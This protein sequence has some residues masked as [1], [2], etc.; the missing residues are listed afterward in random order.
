MSAACLGPG[1]M[2]CAVLPCLTRRADIQLLM[3]GKKSHSVSP[4]EYVIAAINIYLDIVQ[5]FLHILRILAE[6]RR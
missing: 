2:R 5:L 4:D 3:G 6:M 1:L